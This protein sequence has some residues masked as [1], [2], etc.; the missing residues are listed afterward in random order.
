MSKQKSSVKKTLITN[1]CL[2]LIVAGVYLM[3]FWPFGELLRGPAMKGNTG[4]DNV[5]LQIAVSEQSDVAAY[6]D[7]LDARGETAT[8]FFNDQRQEAAQK[9]L[10]VL[11]RGHGIGTYTCDEDKGSMYVGAGYSVPVMSYAQS[12]G[13]VQ[14]GTSIDVAKM[15]SRADW[16]DTLCASL[17]R[18]MFLLIQ[19]DND[20]DDFEKIVQIVRDKGY[21]I[22]KIDEML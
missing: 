4:Q 16:E 18:D 2:M 22:L 19:A 8:F 14:V 15:Q 21:T 6:M 10:M 9:A 20:F 12:G 17:S 13:A 7:W 1:A 5:G 11:K 3:A